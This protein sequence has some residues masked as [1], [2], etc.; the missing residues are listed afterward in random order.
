MVQLSDEQL[1]ELLTAYLDGEVDAREKAFVE[2]LLREDRRASTLFAELRGISAAAAGLPRHDAPAQLADDIQQWIEKD[3]LLGR[4]G[5]NGEF[6]GPVHRN[7]VWRNILATA[8]VLGLCSA[9]ALYY[10]SVQ[11][12]F[13]SAPVATNVRG[14]SPAPDRIDGDLAAKK[15]P[16]NDRSAESMSPPS[17]ESLANFA[18]E[19]VNL[20][21][22]SRAASRETRDFSENESSFPLSRGVE[23]TLNVADSGGLNSVSGG[24]ERALRAV[25]ARGWDDAWSFGAEA[26]SGSRREEAARMRRGI[27]ASDPRK[28]TWTVRVPVSKLPALADALLTEDEGTRAQAS[29]S[30]G[31]AVIR[32][33]PGV[34]EAMARA[35]KAWRRERAARTETE[36][37]SPRGDVP[38]PAARESMGGPFAELF[39]IIGL[40]DGAGSLV[41]PPAPEGVEEAASEGEAAQTVA[42]LAPSGEATESEVGGSVPTGSG[43][44]DSTAE[45]VRRNEAEAASA[46]FVEDSSRPAAPGLVERRMKRLRDAPERPVRVEPELRQRWSDAEGSAA[47]EE[48]YVTLRITV[49]SGSDGKGEVD[50]SPRHPTRPRGGR[51]GEPGRNGTSAAG[52]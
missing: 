49:T 28:R 44:A 11:S 14:V 3:A 29:V 47:I 16:E 20:A 43:H 26:R 21:D 45:P 25:A 27:A 50:Q 41:G 12:M 9:A 40:P 24:V 5:Q 31:E 13:K 32:G 19:V 7:R 33:G 23:L 34:R 22:A 15:G 6:R 37:I 8:A 48:A 4:H 17:E 36:R 42:A 18:R 35:D 51:T 39:K 10:Q 30:A 1:G 46:T 2:H 52:R 38:S